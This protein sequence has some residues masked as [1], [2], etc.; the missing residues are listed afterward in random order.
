MVRVD[1]A[2]IA[3][4]NATGATR[5]MSDNWVAPGAATMTEA[6][7][8][9][10]NW[11]PTSAQVAISLTTATVS[12]ANGEAAMST[13]GAHSSLTLANVELALL[14][15]CQRDSGLFRHPARRIK[16]CHHD[17]VVRLV[18]EIRENVLGGVA[19]KPGGSCGGTVHIAG[20]EEV[21]RFGALVDVPQVVELRFHT[22]CRRRGGLFGGGFDFQRS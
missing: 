4:W 10:P 18:F 14:A 13:P 11:R 17:G 6:A 3:E 9:E 2:T 7:R 16:F 22:G 15:A 5:G 19:E 8:V 12:G 1:W 21:V 20:D